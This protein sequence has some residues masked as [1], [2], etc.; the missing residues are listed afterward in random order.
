M[1]IDDLRYLSL[2]EYF[3]YFNSIL[4]SEYNIESLTKK[5]TKLPFD[6]TIPYFTRRQL[7][8]YDKRFELI[9][10]V[11]DHSE[12][13]ILGSVV[14]YIDITLRELVSIFGNPNYSYLPYDN[15]AHFI[16]RS[17]SPNIIIRTA[18]H[19]SYLESFD[20]YKLKKINK[21]NI[22]DELFSVRMKF[23]DFSIKT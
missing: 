1:E 19:L 17:K 7:V 14:W 13:N 4:H 16:F 12:K 2:R 11:Y 9:E 18:I 21:L 6:E 20:Y 22:E 5:F 23:I 3:E 8:P 10:V 15:T